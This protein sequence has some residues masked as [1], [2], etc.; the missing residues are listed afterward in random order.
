M[1]SDVNPK[2]VG[3]CILRAEELVLIKKINN[4]VKSVTTKKPG[5]QSTG[6]VHILMNA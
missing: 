4:K 6:P 1:L 2:S 3:K 5:A